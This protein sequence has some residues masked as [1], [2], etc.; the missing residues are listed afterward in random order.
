MKKSTIRLEADIKPNMT[1]RE[2]LLALLQGDDAMR[3]LLQTTVQSV[4]EA[5]MEEALERRETLQEEKPPKPSVFVTMEKRM[6]RERL[7]EQLPQEGRR[8]VVALAR[9]GGEERIVFRDVPVRAWFAPHVYLVAGSKIATGDADAEGHPLGVF[10]P[11]ETVTLGELA[12]MVVKASALRWAPSFAPQESDTTAQP[13]NLSAKDHWSAPF[14]A[15]AE[16]MGLSLFADPSRDVESPITRAEAVATI[17]EALRIPTG[18]RPAEFADVPGSHLYT[19][20]IATAAYFDVVDGAVN[21][22]RPDAP[23]LRSEVAK[24]IAVALRVTE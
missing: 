9:E 4:L 2:Q 15:A 14:I 11:E 8:L 23:A 19:R 17:L 22:F 6:R 18:S 7:M 16:G 21:G 10:R 13:R 24:M 3:A 20:A 5:E 1:T 12:K